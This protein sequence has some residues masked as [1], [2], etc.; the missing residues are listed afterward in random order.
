MVPKQELVLNQWNV[1]KKHF[2]AESVKHVLLHTS[3]FTNLV[4]LIWCCIVFRPIDLILGVTKHI[5]NF[6]I[7]F[8]QQVL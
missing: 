2:K 8:L 4:L 3:T 7:S 6:Y 1:V 5:L